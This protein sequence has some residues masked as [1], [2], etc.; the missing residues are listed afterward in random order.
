MKTSLLAVALLGAAVL[1][2]VHAGPPVVS[3]VRSSQRPG[4]KLVDIYYDVSGGD[5][6]TLTVEMQVSNDNGATY[7]V[8]AFSFSGAVGSGIAPGSNK[9]A[10]WDAGFD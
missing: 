7:A 2:P 3:N 1:L 9:Y 6:A 5:T 10:V 8:P 4:T